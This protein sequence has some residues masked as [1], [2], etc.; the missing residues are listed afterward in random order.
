MPAAG[1]YTFFVQ[2]SEYGDD[3]HVTP[4][5]RESLVMMMTMKTR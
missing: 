3:K 1:Q 4:E 5:P 2:K